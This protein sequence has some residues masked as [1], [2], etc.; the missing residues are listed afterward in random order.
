MSAVGLS[1]HCI[2]KTGAEY[3][4]PV[5]ALSYLIMSK[6]KKRGALAG[7][8][9]LALGL[10]IAAAQWKGEEKTGGFPAGPS[11]RKD[12]A[13]FSP[14]ASPE[15]ESA[16]AAV[17]SSQEPSKEMRSSSPVPGSADSSGMMESAV[18]NPAGRPMPPP[19]AVFDRIWK[20]KP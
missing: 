11:E 18:G 17:G 15:N 13:A 6:I 5:F 8:A 9:F 16:S 7:F 20:R 3:P 14:E 4:A 2:P 10:V 12:S 1:S 19:P